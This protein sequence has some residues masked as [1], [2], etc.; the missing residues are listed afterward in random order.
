MYFV[1]HT[2]FF[3]TLWTS[4]SWIAATPLEQRYRPDAD[5]AYLGFSKNDSF[6]SADA[7]TYVGCSAAC[8]QY[9]NCKSFSFN[10]EIGGCQIYNLSVNDNLDLEYDSNNYFYDITCETDPICGARGWDY[11]WRP[12]E[13]PNNVT[14]QSCKDKCAGLSD[15]KSYAYGNQ[16]CFLYDVPVDGNIGGD[17]RVAPYTFYDRRCFTNNTSRSTSTTTTKSSVMIKSTS[18][19]SSS[20]KKSTT[21][22]VTSNIT[23]LTSDISSRMPTASSTSKTSGSRISTSSTITSKF[24]SSSTSKQASK[25]TKVSSTSL[26]ISDSVYFC[27]IAT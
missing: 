13:Y 23:L 18:T 4:S 17:S 24:S 1:W 22:S 7:N 6:A 26:T 15:C 3:G 10:Q 19:S 25:T 9:S 16:E 21:S 20:T 11:R 5:C 12:F 8:F 14:E 27:T 2:L